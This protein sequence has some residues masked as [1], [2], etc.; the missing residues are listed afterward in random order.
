V[1]AVDN[2]YGSPK[3]VTQA[4][5]LLEGDWLIASGNNLK[6]TFERFD[7]NRNTHGDNQTR[8]S[9]V[10]ELTPVQFVQLRAGVRDYYGPASIPS[11]RTKLFFVQLH[12]F[13]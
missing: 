5:A 2:D 13:F 12:G 1:D 8:W 7:P 4:A 11:Q 6:L 3:G 10:Y 9:L